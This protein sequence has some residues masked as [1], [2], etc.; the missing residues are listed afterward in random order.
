MC[1][2]VHVCVGGVYGLLSVYLHLCCRIKRFIRFF[3][4]VQTEVC[5]CPCMY[6]HVCLFP[7][8]SEFHQDVCV[9]VWVCGQ[10]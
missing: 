2:Y 10:V 5:L 1:A 7:A 4:G 3:G 9:F 8:H 6:V